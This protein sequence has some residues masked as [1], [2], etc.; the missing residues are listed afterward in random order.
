MRLMQLARRLAGRPGPVA[1]ARHGD[2][3]WDWAL[4]KIARH[5]V[6]AKHVLGPPGLK[7]CLPGIRR[8]ATGG[9]LGASVAGSTRL[10]VLHKDHVDTL[11]FPDLLATLE[12][13]EPINA[14]PVFVL[15]K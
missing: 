12:M 7:A 10:L 8:Y 15:F 11:D 4:T 3:Y 5:D 9:R 13:F 6:R 14:S 1:Q 2:P